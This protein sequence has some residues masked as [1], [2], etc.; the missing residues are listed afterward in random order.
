MKSN[1]KK[2]IFGYGSLIS[3]KSIVHTIKKDPGI[4]Y[5]VVLKGWIRDWSIV[6][7]NS[8][9]IRR[10]ELLPDHTIPPC[11]AALNIRRPKKGEVATNPNGVLFEV[12]DEDIKRMDEREEHYIREDV[13][14]DIVGLYEVGARVYAYVGKKGFCV[15]ENDKRKVILPKSYLKLIEDNFNKEELEHFKRT[16]KA[17]QHPIM[18]TI[19]SSEL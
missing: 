11:V 15:S 2:Y 19:H 17:T 14:Q 6:L 7:D 10:F 9:T 3:K 12:N 4:L 5:P 16:T 1:L 18:N 13:T 8:T